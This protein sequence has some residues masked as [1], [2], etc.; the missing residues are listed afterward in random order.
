MASRL[1]QVKVEYVAVSKV[2][3]EEEKVGRHERIARVIADFYASYKGDLTADYSPARALEYEFSRFCLDERT[4]EGQMLK[5]WMEGLTA[6]AEDSAGKERLTHHSILV[7]MRKFESNFAKEYNVGAQHRLYLRLLIQRMLFPRIWD[8]CC[9][10]EDGSGDSKEKDEVYVAQSDWLRC[11][12]LE[13]LGV[14]PPFLM[15]EAVKQAVMQKMSAGSS[16]WS[17][18]KEGEAGVED[19]KGVGGGQIPRELPTALK[20]LLHLEGKEEKEGEEG[21]EGGK[22]VSTGGEKDE[23]DRLF[24]K[25]GHGDRGVV[26]GGNLFDKF[27]KPSDGVSPSVSPSP[28]SSPLS[29]AALHSVLLPPLPPLPSKESHSPRPPQPPL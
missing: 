11:V 15:P 28:S 4:K 3:E 5:K 13:Q 8:V 19:E 21:A 22:G 25:G 18:G 29:T 16:R 7:W 2:T 23:F 14:T 17:K 26:V 24:V 27:E 9:I 12:K 1:S 6:Q 20:E 10:I